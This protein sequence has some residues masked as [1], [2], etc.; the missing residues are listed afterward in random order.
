[1]EQ[2]LT[3]QLA[4][5]L[6]YF[7]QPVRLLA[8]LQALKERGLHTVVYTGYRLGVLAHRPEPEVH[9]ALELTDLLIDGPF[10]AALSD[11]AGEWRGTRNQRMIANPGK[12]V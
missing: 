1:M 5:G 10:V 6:L 7:F 12:I 3:G 2:Y 8:L 11:G 4:S 9:A